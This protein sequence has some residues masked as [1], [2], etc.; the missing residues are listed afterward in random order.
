MAK[1]SELFQDDLFPP[2]LVTW[3]PWQPAAA[4][5]ASQPAPAR[6][7]SLQPPGM[8]PLSAHTVGAAKEPAKPPQKAKPD[9]IKS[10]V[11]TDPKEKQD[12]IMKSMSA[13]VQIN[14]KLEQDNMEGV[15]E[16]EWEQ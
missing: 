12:S 9:L 15:D 8:Q 16:A 7:A 11:P 10:H 4:W 1:S 14:L 13:K 6:T 3:S 5:L 2:T